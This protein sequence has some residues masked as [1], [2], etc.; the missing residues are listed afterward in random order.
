MAIVIDEGAG[1]LTI[2]D[3]AITF[4]YGAE[5]GQTKVA[6]ITITPAGGVSSLPIAIEGASGLPAVFDSVTVTEYT[7]GDTIPDPVLTQVDP[8]GPGESAHYTLEFGV[9]KGDT[10]AAGTFAFLAGTDVDDADLAAGYTVV[11]NADG[12][13]VEFAAMKSGDLYWPGTGI[14]ATSSANLTPRAIKTITIPARP[15]AYRVKPFAQ[16][17]VTGSAD[18]RVDLIAYLGDPDSGGVEIGRGNG[19]AGT[20]PPTVTLIPANPPTSDQATYAKVAANTSATIYLRAVNQGN[21]SANFS[22]PASPQTTFNVEAID[23]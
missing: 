1:T 9:H 13:G 5:V 7:P 21:A 20:N 14:A 4:P 3:C 15:R 19:T 22:T 16:T 6:T 8:G 2:T 11:V 23:L 12:D 17:T 18:T 10:G